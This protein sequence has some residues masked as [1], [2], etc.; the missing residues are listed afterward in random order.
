MLQLVLILS[1]FLV[2]PASSTVPK[3]TTTANN[4]ADPNRRQ[5]NN[6][7][8]NNNNNTKKRLWWSPGLVC[9]HGCPFRVVLLFTF[10]TSQQLAAFQ[11][12]RQARPA[13]LLW[14]WRFL[15]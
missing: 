7:N 10:G 1:S 9:R 14:C 2:V 12:E 13:S 6:H 3:A 5:P 8:S 15:G 4:N 11:Q